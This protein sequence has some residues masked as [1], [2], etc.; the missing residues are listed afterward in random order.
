MDFLVFGAGA[1]GSVFGGLLKKAGHAVWLHGREDSM[2]AIRQRGLEIGGIWGEHHVDDL[3]LS[4]DLD[5]IPRRSFENVL[6]TVKAF[7]TAAAANQLKPFIGEETLVYSLQ[8]G[9]GNWETIAGVVGWERTVGGRVIF[10]A[11]RPGPG[12]VEVTVYAEEV[13]LG[14]LSPGTDRGRIEAVARALSE[15]G[16]PTLATEEIAKY[17]WAKVLYNAALNPLSVL[18]NASYGQLAASEHAR[19]I[20]EQV[21]REIFEVARAE[22]VP[23]FWDR[24]EGYLEKFYGQEIP[25][26][27]GHRSSMLQA[28]EEGRRVDVDSLNGHIAQLAERHGVEAP[29]NRLLT[30]LVKA[31]SEGSFGSSL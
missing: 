22:G 3:G 18:L 15:S 13:M 5:A 24:P 10:G 25:S 17:L 4:W 9:L 1:I 30:A 26:T 12:A 7:D 29:T 14:A 20:M 27:A 21:V 6:L 8:N 16:I 2:Q 28:I 11:R 19:G 31:R 23:L